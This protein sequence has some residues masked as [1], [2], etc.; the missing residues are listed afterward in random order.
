VQ[1]VFV[2]KYLAEFC[3]H[4]DGSLTR[5]GYFCR[6]TI[7]HFGG[8]EMV[9]IKTRVWSHFCVSPGVSDPSWAEAFSSFCP[10]LILEQVCSL[11]VIPACQHTHGYLQHQHLKPPLDS[12]DFPVQL[13]RKA[14]LALQLPLLKAKR[15]GGKKTIISRIS[16]S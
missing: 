16:G 5:K 8:G 3:E 7:I 10:S 12:Q 15:K 11:S 9:H 4:K 6:Y 14:G 1:T 2:V 13:L